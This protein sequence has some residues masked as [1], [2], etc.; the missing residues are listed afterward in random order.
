MWK[1]ILN[2]VFTFKDW[3]KSNTWLIGS[4]IKEHRPTV[5]DKPSR[6]KTYSHAVGHLS[7]GVD[8]WD[9]LCWQ[10]GADV[11]H[12]ELLHNSANSL[13]LTVPPQP[14]HGGH[15]LQR[16]VVHAAGQVGELTLHIHAFC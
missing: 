9:F 11:L 16:A 14:H 2:S 13:L 15:V 3:A 8:R 4:G 12:S 6:W 1:K 7:A 10:N 5:N